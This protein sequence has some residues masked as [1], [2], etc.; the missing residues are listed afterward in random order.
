MFS[1]ILSFVWKGISH[2]L[3]LILLLS[4]VCVLLPVGNDLSH[5]YQEKS[6]EHYSSQ[7]RS[8]EHVYCKLSTTG[9]GQDA[10]QNSNCNCYNQTKGKPIFELYYQDFIHFTSSSD[11]QLFSV[12]LG[13]HSF[14]SHFPG[15][16]TLESLSIRKVSFL[17]QGSKISKISNGSKREY[18]K[19][20]LHRFSHSIE[21]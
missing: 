16:L 10:V 17:S 21:I 20:V 8:Q 14:K 3:W 6:K 11:C 7:D 13:G 2:T 5:S 4:S 19:E 9:I 1:T 12:L 18:R 15:R